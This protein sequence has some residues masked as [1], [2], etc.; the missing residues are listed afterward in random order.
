MSVLC[1]YAHWVFANY[2]LVFVV[3]QDNYTPL[4]LALKEERLKVAEVSVKMNAS[5]HAVDS[6]RR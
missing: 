1:V 5:V 3:L 6:L 2:E 4:I